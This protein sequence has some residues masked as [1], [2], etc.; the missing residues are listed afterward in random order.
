MAPAKGG[1]RDCQNTYA[2]VGLVA[3]KAGE[4]KMF[5]GIQC[6]WCR[7]VEWGQW[8]APSAATVAA[9]KAQHPS[10]I[11]GGAVHE[12][13]QVRRMPRLGSL[14]PLRFTLSRQVKALLPAG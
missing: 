1:A 13:H 4:K 7:N 5:I 12:G 10:P 14:R 2:L 9:D 8:H 11:P 3:W 6:G